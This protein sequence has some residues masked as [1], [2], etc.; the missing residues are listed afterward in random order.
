V[1]DDVIP[2]AHMVRDF[3]TW[4]GE[5]DLEADDSLDLT[6]A[7]LEEDDAVMERARLATRGFQHG[8]AVR[9]VSHDD[10]VISLSV[11]LLRSSTEALLSVADHR[12]TM[13]A[14]GAVMLLS[15]SSTVI[16]SFDDEGDQL[17]LISVAV[18]DHHITLMS[19]AAPGL[20]DVETLRQ[21]ASTQHR[22]IAVA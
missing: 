2:Y 4:F 17:Q 3:S 18:G 21:I 14:A 16:A 13:T 11:Y 5:G 1:V 15:T 8:R 20:V 12:E 7:A 9:W 22:L 10:I 6:A 19:R